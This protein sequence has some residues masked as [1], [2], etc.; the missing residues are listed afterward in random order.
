MVG[1]SHRAFAVKLGAGAMLLVSFFPGGIS[2]V[3]M[4]SASTILFV[5]G[6]VLDELEK[7]RRL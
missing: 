6:L 3:V 1:A 5:L 2:G 7:W 4:A